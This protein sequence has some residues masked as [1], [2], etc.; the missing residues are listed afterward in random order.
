MPETKKPAEGAQKGKQRIVLVARSLQM[1]GV[2]RNTVNLADMLAEMGHDVH[3]LA[4]KKRAALR[5]DPA[6]TVHFFDFDKF[7]RFTGIGLIYDLLTRALLA[8]LIP[9]S[10]FIWRGLY[11]SLYFKWWLRV[12]ERRTGPVDKV[13]VRGHGAFEL[14]WAS[15]DPRIYRVIVSPQAMTGTRLQRIYTRLLYGGKPLVVNSTGTRDSLLERLNASGTTPRSLQ[16]IPN[17]IPIE[18]I[19]RLSDEAAPLPERPY[20]V[21]VGRL[22]KQKNQRLLLQAYALA[23]PEER[24]VIVGGGQDEPDL[25]KLAGELGIEER[26]LFVGE[27]KNPYPW[28]KGARLFVLSSLFEG[29]GLVMVESFVCGTPVVAVDCRGGVRDILIG[30]QAQFI[31]PLEPQGLADTIRK[32][33]QAPPTLTS[34][35]YERFDSRNVARQF[36]ELN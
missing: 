31:A 3:I 18:R 11:T 12:L 23:S 6:V 26:V 5:P 20:I 1:G 7:N 33:L 8:N 32:A 14:L 25:R 13:L 35:L 15:N 29:F 28:M 30:E 27:Q 36:L 19:R 34:E 9:R 2:E 21:H 22:T 16:L 24:L 10:G 17:P 4:F